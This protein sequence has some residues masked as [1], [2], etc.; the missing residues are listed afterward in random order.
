MTMMMMTLIVKIITNTR[1]CN[2]YIFPLWSCSQSRPTWPPHSWG[3]LD[4]TQTPYSL[5]FLWM[6]DQPHAETST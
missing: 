1:V 6:S 2:I 3:F 5:G 4:H